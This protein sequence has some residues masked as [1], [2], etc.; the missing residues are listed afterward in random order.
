[1]QV[2]TKIP[3]FSQKIDVLLAV[4]NVKRMKNILY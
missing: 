4:A 2:K 3:Y 1:M